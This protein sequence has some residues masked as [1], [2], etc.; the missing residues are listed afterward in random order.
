MLTV[1]ALDFGVLNY[2][3]DGEMNSLNHLSGKRQPGLV[4]WQQ[5]SQ[6]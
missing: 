6:R 2:F 1:T 5:P 3:F 4:V